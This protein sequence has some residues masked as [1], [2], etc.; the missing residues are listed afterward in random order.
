MNNG[1][2]AT[3]EGITRT[4]KGSLALNLRVARSGQPSFAVAVDTAQYSHLAPGYC[5][6]VHD[7]QGQGVDDV[8]LFANPKMMD[9]QSML[10]A[11]TRLK[12]G[13]FRMYGSDI[14]LDQIRNKL[15]VDH[16]KQNA[17][18]EGLWQ[19]RAALRVP[20]MEQ[21]YDQVLRR[22]QGVQR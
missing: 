8:L 22:Q 18:Q 13:R 16:L 21:D 17:T 14:E 12:A 7:A 1:D 15:G 10:V 2:L 11:F 6:T 20:T 9:N 3:V 4:E 5:R 19:E